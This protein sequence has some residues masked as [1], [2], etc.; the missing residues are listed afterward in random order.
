MF[1][2]A[3]KALKEAGREISLSRSCNADVDIDMTGNLTSLSTVAIQATIQY[4]YSIGSEEGSFEKYKTAE[5]LYMTV[6]SGLL[7]VQIPLHCTIVCF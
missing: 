2:D 5:L 3:Q 6:S 4:L 7:N 1:K